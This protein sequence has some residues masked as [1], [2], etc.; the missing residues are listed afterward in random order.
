[1]MVLVAAGL[2]AGYVNAVAGAGSLLTLPA[3]VFTGLDASAA[4]ATNRIAIVAQTVASIEGYRRGGVAAT[5]NALWLCIP[6]VLGAVA[7]AY[8][9]TILEPP[10]MGIVIAVVMVVMLGLSFIRPHARER[11]STFR[12]NPGML[13]GFVVMGFYGGFVQAGIG[14]LII[15]FMTSLYDVDLIS[16]NAVK[17][18][19]VLALTFA[20]L[21]V[22]AARH[23]T[24]DWLRGGVL[25]ASTSAGGYMGAR[26]ALKRGEGF[27]RF[28][29]VVAV[30]ASAAK[31]IVDSL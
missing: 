23:E 7:G 26:G 27:V 10:T 5:R 30:L 6:A 21:L 20:A 19:V 12:L 28:A 17:L 18:V 14:I 31:L 16:T 1:M 29:V 13:L 15:L 9:A 8:V 4:N 22:F 25:A 2:F 11:V 3:L 24:L